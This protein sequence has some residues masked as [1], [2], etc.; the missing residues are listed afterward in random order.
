MGFSI[1]SRCSR[2]STGGLCKYE[3]Y[4]VFTNGPN[5]IDTT[6]KERFNFGIGSDFSSGIDLFFFS[7][8]TEPD[9]Y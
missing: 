1:D 8:R 7:V 3:T 6:L 2:A 5:S 9:V 4:Y